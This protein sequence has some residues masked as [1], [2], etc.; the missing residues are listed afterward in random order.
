MK[1]L[2]FALLLTSCTRQAFEMEE[3]ADDVIKQKRGVDI[4]IEPVEEKR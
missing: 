1:W 3:L 4:H 2:L